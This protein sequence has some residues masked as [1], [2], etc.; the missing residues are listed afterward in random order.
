MCRLEFEKRNEQQWAKDN[1]HIAAPTS[2]KEWIKTNPGGIEVLGRSIKA[3]LEAYDSHFSNVK[4]KEKKE[5]YTLWYL[6]FSHQTLNEN[7]GK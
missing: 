5:F 3:S 7:N 4:G 2:I 1:K 6:K